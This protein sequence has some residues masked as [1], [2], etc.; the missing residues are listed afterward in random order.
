MI[1]IKR[2][3]AIIIMLTVLVGWFHP[4]EIVAA[5]LELEI[6]SVKRS[7]LSAEPVFIDITLRNK[8]STDTVQVNPNLMVETQSVSIFIA[9]GE[10]PF[11]KYSTSLHIEPSLPPRK[12]A[13]SKSVVH[14]QLV[15]HNGLTKDFAFP[16]VGVYRIRVVYNLF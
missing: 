5:D 6:K 11:L 13:P 3:A 16:N 2:Y 15:L 14:R 9:R 8:N 7:Y 1:L 12:L 4:N 10:G